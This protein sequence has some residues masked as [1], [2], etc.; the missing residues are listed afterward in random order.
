MTLLE[1]GYIIDAKNKHLHWMVYS[2]S[3]DW[4]KYQKAP[5]IAHYCSMVKTIFESMFDTDYINSHKNLAVLYSVDGPITFRENNLIFLSV[6]HNP[7]QC[8]YQ[9]S[10]ELCH[11]M[12]PGKVCK[13]FQWLEESLC[14]LSSLHTLTV[15]MESEE[16][17][18]IKN[19]IYQYIKCVITDASK[20][21]EDATLS[22]FIENN[23][24]ALSSEPCKDNYSY[25]KAIA[26]QLH[27]IF[28]E[29]RKLWNIIPYL[30]EL[31]DAMTLKEA[32]GH[33]GYASGIPDATS[34]LI[35]LMC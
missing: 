28:Q 8:I 11:F 3:E 30:N 18:K 4:D 20:P 16:D 2:T 7:C 19:V 10:H 12:I 26:L 34:K 27:P 35:S 25:N 13:N 21:I 33:L 24:V 1:A 22:N 29:Y 14:M 31:T 23:I 5:L 17:E 32:F 9:F 6:E 15:I